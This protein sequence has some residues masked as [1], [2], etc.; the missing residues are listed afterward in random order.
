MTEAK[1]I[2]VVVVDDHAVVR[3][4]LSTFLRAFDDLELAGEASNGAEAVRLCH[5]LQP[6]VVLMD[7]KMPEMDGVTATRQIRQNLPA[8]QIIALTSFHEPTSVQEALQAGA[9]G[10]LMKD[11][12]ADELADAIRNAHRGMP[13]LAPEAAKVLLQAS[14]QTPPPGH[15]LTPRE[16]EVL[17]LLVQGLNNNEIAEKLAISVSTAKF[18]VSTILSKL[19]ATS[20]T[21]A[22]ALAVK[23]HLTG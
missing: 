23:H 14:R 2:R 8:I 10:Y 6:D 16:R 4:G 9:I 19:G 5:A 21:E 3:S 13:T 18:H 17:G 22:A 1:P 11:V 7:L 15:D 20:R 12:S